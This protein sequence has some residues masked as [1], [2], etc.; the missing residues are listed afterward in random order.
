MP[1]K[2]IARI[3][4]SSIASI[5]SILEPL[6]QAITELQQFR[7]S[8]E[9]NNQVFPQW[10]HSHGNDRFQNMTVDSVRLEYVYDE[11]NHL[12]EP[13]YVFSGFGTDLNDKVMATN[14]YVVA[15]TQ[16]IELRAPYRE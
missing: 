6:S 12:I 3:L 16:I 8:G 11:L 4:Y 7:Y 10:N 13:Y 15:S 14:W 2:Q 5:L 1:L 9:R